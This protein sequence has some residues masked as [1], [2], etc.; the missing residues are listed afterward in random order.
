M[1]TNYRADNF[2]DSPTSNQVVMEQPCHWL[3][4]DK[5]TQLCY[6]SP[7]AWHTAIQA[8]SLI[9]THPRFSSSPYIC[10]S[11][12]NTNIPSLIR[13]LSD[14]H[15]YTQ[16]IANLTNLTRTHHSCFLLGLQLMTIYVVDYLNVF[17]PLIS[18]CFL[19]CQVS[20]RKCLKHLTW[21]LHQKPIIQLH[22]ELQMRYT[23]MPCD[24]IAN[25]P[26]T[27]KLIVDEFRRRLLPVDWLLRLYFLFFVSS[28]KIVLSFFAVSP[29]MS[30][31][32]AT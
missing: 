3:L 2:N 30:T 24:D 17:G 31:Q 21:V 18:R 22:H 28:D 19:C 14:T 15:E 16:Y 6:Y 10:H 27:T 5:H 7:F 13:L 25:D 20:L 11:C 1:D 23:C 4:R 9:Y 29:I 12:T 26:S 32:Q 8:A